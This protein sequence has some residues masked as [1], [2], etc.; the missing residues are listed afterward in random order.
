MPADSKTLL[1]ILCAFALLCISALG[2]EIQLGDAPRVA[3][4]IE[5]PA[6]TVSV[7]PRDLS[8]DTTSRSAV[9]AFFNT[10]YTPQPSIAWTG[11]DVSPYDPG[12]IGSTFQDATL[13]RVNFYRAM[14]GLPSNIVFD[15]SLS[16]ECQQ[17]A[18]MFSVAGMLSHTPPSSPTAQWPYATANG[19]DA[20]GH[21][22]ISLGSFGPDAMDGLMADPGSNNTVAGHRRWILYPPQQTMGHGS[23]AGG[24]SGTT[25]LFGADA[26]W[27][28]ATFG[29]RPPTPTN[30]P[31]PNAGYFPYQLL[32]F[33][34]SNTFAK[35]PG[36]WTFSMNGA[37]FSAATVT[38]TSNG[39]NLNVQLE[40][41]ANGYGDNT[42][43][44]H[45]LDVP[46]T[47]PTAD[48]TY[49]VTVSNVKV[50]NAPQTFNYS[51]IVF[52][53]ST[54]VSTDPLAN[55][56]TLSTVE[57]TPLPITLTGSNGNTFAIATQPAN[58]ALSGFVASTGAVTY[59]P[60]TGFS[61]SDSFTF[62]ITNGT[63][64][65]PPATISI[66]VLG[67]GGAYPLD[68]LAYLTSQNIPVNATV[69]TTEAMQSKTTLSIKLNFSS[70]MTSADTSTLVTPVSLPT[71][72]TLTNRQVV[73]DIAG[74]IRQYSL[75]DKGQ[76][77]SDPT[78]KLTLSAKQKMGVTTSA[79][80]AK[81]TVK[82]SKA[83][84]HT[85][86][87]AAG[88]KGDKVY[89]NQ[90]IALPVTVVI[91][92]A[93][94]STVVHGTLTVNYSAKPGKTGTAKGAL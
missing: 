2:G 22:N 1:Q 42:L 63:K 33:D 83:D 8:V 38:M 87:A 13:F 62:T 16:A 81:F 84:L 4:P 57:N 24:V 45:A 3:A 92:D 14:A 79:G 67:S 68:L 80:I 23:V 46:L 32:P 69:Q 93:A 89:T 75:N 88:L 74:V 28:I 51:V 36:R 40:T 20:A 53:P 6:G 58:G 17:A 91:V 34:Y 41:V 71:G 47:A 59:T 48:T 60:T 25:T 39:A 77:T 11:S 21:S 72:F 82:L 44:W 30:V 56:Q 76:A 55:A 85:T 19:A 5:A 78:S 15:S 70:M 31:W 12:T 86:L 50:N 10:N 26:L 73:V 94:A 65:S 35:I 64:V 27:V 43:V 29:T 9:V 18:L 66:N 52:D 90:M 49:A 61:G 54:G 7:A 37:D